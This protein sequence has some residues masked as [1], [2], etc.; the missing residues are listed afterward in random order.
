MECFSGMIK[1]SLPFVFHED[2]D[3]FREREKYLINFFN[4]LNENFEPLCAIF[5]FIHSFLLIL[6]TGANNFR[7][8]VQ[9]PTKNAFFSPTS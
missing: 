4:C 1:S 3:F 5:I 9:L 7:L 8:D 6:L 2:Y